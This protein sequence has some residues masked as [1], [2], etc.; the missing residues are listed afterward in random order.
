MRLLQ[1][2]SLQPGVALRGVP[3]GSTFLQIESLRRPENP[4]PIPGRLH[5][6]P[7]RG[8]SA[9][10]PGFGALVVGW[11]GGLAGEFATHATRLVSNVDPD[12]CRGCVHGAMHALGSG[13]NR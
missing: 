6:P 9:C 11:G 10:F 7:S 3:A 8:R 4:S 12:T 1:S 2:V 13:D 5:V